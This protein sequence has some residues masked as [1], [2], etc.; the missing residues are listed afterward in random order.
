MTGKA[1]WDEHRGESDPRYSQ[2]LERG[3]AILSCFSVESPVLGIADLAERLNL[4]RPTTHRYAATL[5][6]LGYLE[7]NSDRKY[8]LGLKVTDLGMSA[9]GATG[10]G[11]RTR[12]YVE[13]LRRDTGI[14]VV[15]AVLDGVEVLCL[16]HAR[17][18]RQGQYEVDLNFEVGSRLPAYCTAAGKVLLAHLPEKE[19]KRLLANIKLLKMGP[20]AITVKKRLSSQLDEISKGA[21]AV[22][23]QELALRVQAI[24]WPIRSSN[25]EVV[26]AVMLV[27]PLSVTTV[28]EMSSS[29]LAH[30]RAAASS[31]SMMLGYR[32]RT[33]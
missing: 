22:D 32:H 18:S 2:S 30:L 28:Q 11:H 4:S 10:L 27:A 16:E 12:P 8:R 25:A 23:D 19:R 13:R 5:A 7:Q 17:G 21:L 29:C 31:M 9:L 20:G 14:T 33:V 26:A 1:A 24:A 3:L 6:E 15:V